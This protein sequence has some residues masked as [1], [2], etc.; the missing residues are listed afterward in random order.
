RG[1]STA[2]ER[3]RTL[4]RRVGVRLG[5]ARLRERSLGLAQGIARVRVVEDGDDVAG[6]DR[7]ALVHADL[8]DAP[9]HL[10]REREVAAGR[11][12]DATAEGDGV[13][14]GDELRCFAMH[15]HRLFALRLF[16]LAMAR[17]EGQKYGD[18]GALHGAPA[19][20]CTSIHASASCA[21]A[22][23]SD[24]FASIRA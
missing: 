21:R 14:D 6:L 3:L 17:G 24:T 2:Y 18:Y 10:R 13:V 19:A 1:D 4:E 9:R 12:L 7:V 8:R 16:G 15:G 11:R 20:C 22:S 23:R 5:G